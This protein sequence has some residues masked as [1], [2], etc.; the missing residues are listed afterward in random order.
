M[1][2]CTL[3]NAQK[4]LTE[5]P[6]ARGVKDG[7]AYWC[8]PCHAARSKAWRLANP[9]KAKETRDKYRMR[10]PASHRRSTLRRYYGM[11]LE[12]YDALL[13]A[14]SGE[15]AICR[16]RQADAAKKFLCVDHIENT[17]LVRGLL[18]STCNSAIGMLRHDPKLLRRAIDYL[19]RKPVFE[20]RLVPQGVHRNRL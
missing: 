17:T 19:G 7:H 5:F 16:R 20:G 9:E 10:N 11:E 3:C 14:Q 8:K 15:C 1:K 2:S 12:D 13:Q 4:P 18:C 6:R